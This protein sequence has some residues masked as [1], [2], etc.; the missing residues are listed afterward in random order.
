VQRRRFLST[1]VGGTVVLAA[2]P[3]MAVATDHLCA[4]EGVADITPPLGIE[5]AGFHRPPG[6]ERRIRAIRQ[7]CDVR[8]L[9]LRVGST[10]VALCSLD[11]LG[12]DATTAKRIQDSAAKRTAIPAE[13]IHVAA[14]HDHSMPTFQTLRQWGALSP[15]FMAPVERHTVEAIVA[16]RADLAPA[17]LYSY[18][19]LAI[20]RDSPLRD[21]LVVGYTDRLIG[22]LPDPAAYRLGEYSALVVPKILDLPPYQPTAARDMTSVAI[23][24]LKQTVG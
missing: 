19:G 16:A 2:T 22:Y 3:A 10:Q 18:Y 8:A 6:H 15:E 11:A 13:N 12:V 5:M 4:G 14:T 24:L 20:R 1:M 9:V 23:A 17:E 7:A 21:T